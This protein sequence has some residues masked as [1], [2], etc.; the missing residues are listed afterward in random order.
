MAGFE[1]AAKA[2]KDD[3]KQEGVVLLTTAEAFVSKVRF[4]IVPTVP[5]ETTT[6]GKNSDASVSHLDQMK[7]EEPTTI[8]SP[9]ENSDSSVSH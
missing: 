7:K 9:E 6:P 8:A 5:A 2:F 4:P 3:M 1:Y